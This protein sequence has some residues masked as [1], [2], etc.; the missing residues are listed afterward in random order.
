MA[1]QSWKQKQK[2]KTERNIFIS[3]THSYH[4]DTVGAMSVSGKSLFTFPY[5]KLLFPVVRAEQGVRS[6]DPPSMYLADFEKKLKQYHRRAAG[7]IIEPLVQGAGGMV[8]W[9]EAVVQE[10]CHL[11]KKYGLYLIFDEVMTGFGRTG[12]YFAFQKLGVVPDILCLS[13]GLTGGCLPLALTVA[14]KEIYNSFLSKKKQHLFF[15][16]HSFTGNPI[17]CAAAVANIQTMKKRN[18][19]KEWKRINTFHQK[20]IIRLKKP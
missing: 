2:N 19:K 12:S 15:H 16:G 17:S 14:N 5:Q 18:L 10:I 20:K 8:M 11:T 9:P 3:F 4:G 1:V 7:V 13:K 6:D